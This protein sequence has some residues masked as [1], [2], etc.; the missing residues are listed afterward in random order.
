MNDRTRAD[1]I[2]FKIREVF[3]FYG[4]TLDDRSVDIWLKALTGH[5]ADVIAIAF[6]Q[7]IEGKSGNA[8]NHAPRP[9]QI[10]EL[11]A[12]EGVRRKAHTPHDEPQEKPADPTIAKA[13]VICMRRFYGWAP[14]D[15]NP[16]INLSFERAIEIVNREAAKYD[17]AEAIPDKYKLPQY[18]GGQDDFL[19]GA[20]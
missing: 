5:S 14:R 16:Q 1:D 6:D 10:L 13:W 2:E 8:S 19:G 9:K 11:I 15:T 18:W 17:N 12:R 7:H 20:A 3:N 4:K